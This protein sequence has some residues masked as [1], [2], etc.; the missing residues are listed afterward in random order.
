MGWTASTD[1]LNTCYVY[2]AS[3]EAA[4]E[5]AERHGYAYTVEDSKHVE[6]PVRPGKSYAA[7][8][9]YHAE[10]EDKW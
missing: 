8:F 7:S 4:I 10:D 1:P 5:F 3:K 2:F 6:N 9:K